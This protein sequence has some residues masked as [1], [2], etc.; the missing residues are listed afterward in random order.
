[1]ADV[2]PARENILTQETDYN[3]SVSER[4]FQK[5]GGSINFIND[6]QTQYHTWKLN[7][8]YSNGVGSEIDQVISYPFNFEISGFIYYNDVTGGTGS[9]IVDVLE[10]DN[11]GNLVGSIFS[12]KPEVDSTANSRSSTV[13]DQVN[14]STIANPSGHTLAVLNKTQFD[15][16]NI[17]VF[18]LDA[19]MNS[20]N[21]FML[22][23]WIRGR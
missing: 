23:L 12:T 4:F 6:R 13:Y 10:Y 21:G 11:D 15:A 8:P 14:S 7:G 3:S 1:M 2:S 5:V 17:L 22:G 18:K 20:A 9:T 16:G 19:A